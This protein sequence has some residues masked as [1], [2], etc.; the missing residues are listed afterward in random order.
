MPLLS[1]FQKICNVLVHDIFCFFGIRGKHIAR[2][3]TNRIW[4]HRVHCLLCLCVIY[5]DRSV[6]HNCVPSD[7]FRD[8]VQ[9]SLGV[10]TSNQQQQLR[11]P[12]SLL[13][14]KNN[15]PQSISQTQLSL[16]TDDVKIFFL[17]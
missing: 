1:E 3:V 7:A 10:T 4:L 13:A 12:S 5:Y 2:D 9:S 16:F 6:G 14:E 15:G 11:R 8:L 17:Y